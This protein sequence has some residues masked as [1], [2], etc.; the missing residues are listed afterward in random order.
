MQRIRIKF[1]KGP[2]VKFISHLDMMRCFERALRRAGLPIGYSSG[3]NPRPSIAWGTP[4]Q[5]GIGSI[6]E[7][8]D[9]D[10]N[11]WIKPA[12][13]MQ[14]LN[15]SLPKGFEILE[16]KLDDP[17]GKSLAASMNRAEYK[18]EIEADNIEAVRARIADILKM[19]KIEIASK[20]KVV[21]KKPLLHGLSLNEDPL[22]IILLS[23]VG[24]RGTL[25]P[26]DIL[27]LISGIKAKNIT[28]TKLFVA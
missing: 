17:S 8:A 22:N 16:A 15:A 3:F 4:I 10:M 23:E 5:L 25:K 27:D 20:E 26:K 14:K 18:I 11:G 2:E 6:C 12:D 24:N 19:D 9:L 7:M 28:R 1:T 21:D 13:A